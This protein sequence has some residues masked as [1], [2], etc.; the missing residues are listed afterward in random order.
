MQQRGMHLDSKEEMERIILGRGVL[1]GVQLLSTCSVGSRHSTH[2]HSLLPSL[3]YVGQLL[4]AQD[5][6]EGAAI[7]NMSSIR[8]K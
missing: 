6:Q 5:H 8:G 7:S 4:P 2:L 1:I 3:A